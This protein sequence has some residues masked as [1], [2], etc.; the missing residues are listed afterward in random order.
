M[1][2]IFTI[3]SMFLGIIFLAGC[4][5][6]STNQTQS[7]AP[8]ASVNQPATNQSDVAKQC[9]N[10]PPPG[11][12]PGGV[13][14]IIVTGTDN[15]GCSTYGCK[16]SQEGQVDDINTING[17]NIEKI[18]RRKGEKCATIG[19]DERYNNLPLANEIY[20]YTDPFKSM[21]LEMPYNKNWK[22]T[23]CEIGPFTQF[24]DGAGML[25]YFGQPNSWGPDQYDFRIDKVRSVE[26]IQKELLSGP[27]DSS[28]PR[29]QM[30]KVTIN[31]LDAF[32]WQENGMG[33]MVRIE[34]VGKK[35]NYRFETGVSAENELIKIIKTLK[36]L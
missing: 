3:G 32:R 14:D 10:F 18:D 23:G 25:V 13:G 9:Q 7:V 31:G 16:S 26:N 6:Q 12:C 8:V 5:K 19:P 24:K 4:G 17:V 33:E 15:N 27:E 36:F 11:F 34:V 1:K 20:P 28:L 21:T 22:F 35:Y 30:K 2:K 29:S